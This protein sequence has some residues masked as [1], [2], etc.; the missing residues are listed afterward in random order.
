M[1]I[2]PLRLLPEAEDSLLEAQLECIPD[3]TYRW[4]CRILLP[5]LPRV[6][7]KILTECKYKLVDAH[8][9]S[10]QS[11]LPERVLEFCKNKIYKTYISIYCNILKVYPDMDIKL[12]Y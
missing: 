5:K 1:T 7:D 4:A 2:D 3:S 11:R 12:L 6:L 9:K 8:N 10:F